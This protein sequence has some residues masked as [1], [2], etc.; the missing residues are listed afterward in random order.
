[1]KCKACIETYYELIQRMIVQ[2]IIMLGKLTTQAVFREGY[3][4]INYAKEQ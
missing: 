2:R 3:N 1:M 4:S